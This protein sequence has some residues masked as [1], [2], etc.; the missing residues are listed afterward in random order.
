MTR[1]DKGNYSFPIAKWFESKEESYHERPNKIKRKEKG[2]YVFPNFMA[3][4]MAKVSQRTQYEAEMLSVVF[5]LIGLV[6][7]GIISVFF[8]DLSLI[9]K[10]FTVVN[11]LAGLVF[12]SSRLVTSFQQYQNYLAV[13]GVIEDT[14]FQELKGGFEENEVEKTETSGNG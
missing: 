3:K 9:V 14:A 10:I 7:L 12:L 11:V 8:T 2:N 13:V 6:A 1:E 5:I 4:V